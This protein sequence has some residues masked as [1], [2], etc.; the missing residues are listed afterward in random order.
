MIYDADR[1]TRRTTRYFGQKRFTTPSL[2]A[3]T[4][5][6]NTHTYTLSQRDE[7]AKIYKGYSG[8]YATK[9]DHVP[10]YFFCAKLFGE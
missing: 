6:H 5:T 8:A 1:R 7:Y 10:S 2:A 4:D 3:H 9:R